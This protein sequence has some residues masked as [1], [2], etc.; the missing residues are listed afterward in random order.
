MVQ[1][2]NGEVH[3]GALL[4][5]DAVRFF[6]S[7]IYPILARRRPGVKLRVTGRTAGVDLGG[8]ADCAGV[9]FTGYVE[10]IRTVLSRSAVCVVPLREGGGSRLKILEAMAAGVPVVST[11]VGV[12]GIEAESGRHLLVA[13]TPSD[14]ADAV[15]R[16][17]SDHELASRLSRE[18]RDLVERRYDWSSIGEGFVGVVESVAKTGACCG[19]R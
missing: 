9:E 19:K 1:A 2:G 10:D 18:A 5:Q 11:S 17:L 7:D 14:L 12:E 3:R 4:D 15:E 16:V 13:D 6:A 8:V